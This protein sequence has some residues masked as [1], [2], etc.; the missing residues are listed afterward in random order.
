MKVGDL[1]ELSSYAKKLK[2]NTSLVGKIGIVREIL[3]PSSVHNIYDIYWIGV[4]TRPIY[5]R[6][7]L[8]HC[9]RKG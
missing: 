9:R 4:E 7:E 2:R 8:K 6:S 3:N 5:Y 1:V